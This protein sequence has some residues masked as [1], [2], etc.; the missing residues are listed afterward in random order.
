MKTGPDEA[1]DSLISVCRCATNPAKLAQS[2]AVAV[3]MS[4]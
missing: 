3:R 2:M 4:V 1:A